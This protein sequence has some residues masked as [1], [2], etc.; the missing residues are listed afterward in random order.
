M[1]A[2]GTG[3]RGMD[4][5]QLFPAAMHTTSDFPGLLTSTGNRTLMGAYQ[6]AQSPIKIT[7]A[8]QATMTYFR[9]A[10]RLKLSDV[11]LLER[12][13]ESGEIKSTTRGEAA[14]SYAQDTQ[15]A[16]A[17]TSRFAILLMLLSRLNGLN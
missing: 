8:R 15:S 7:L 3:T 9:P 14:A 12:V 10:N 16:K 2:T 4:A 6:A 5:D 13:T 11:G 17:A 1:E